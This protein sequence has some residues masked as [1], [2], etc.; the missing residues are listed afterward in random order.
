MH[1]YF[2]IY[3]FELHFLYER[4]YKDCYLY[5][6]NIKKVISYLALSKQLLLVIKHDSNFLP[7]NIF[8][9]D[10]IDYTGKLQSLAH[11]QASVGRKTRLEQNVWT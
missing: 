8:G 10:N 3:I 6:N 5:E 9:C 7:R 4:Y 11:I 1:S 2:F